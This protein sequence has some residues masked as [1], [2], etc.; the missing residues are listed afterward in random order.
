MNREEVSLTVTLQE[1]QHIVPKKA[2]AEME[3]AQRARLKH[4]PEEEIVHLKRAVRIDP[5]YI[6]ARNNLGICLMSVDPAFAVAE[7]EEAIKVNPRKGVL[8]NNLAVGYS[9]LDRLPAAERA[10]RT[11]MVLDKTSDRARALLGLILFDQQKYTSET[12]ALLERSSRS[13]S[14]AHVYAARVLVK[15]GEFRKAK[16]HIQAYLSSGE[17]EYREDATELLGF[18]D[19]ADQTTRLS[20][21]RF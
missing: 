17:V 6:A 14:V 15:L 21:D 5:E 2:Q 10:A 1:L 7:W 11:A 4:K 12:L 20:P 9:A 19:R 18:I 3:K 16:T 13:Y 8:F